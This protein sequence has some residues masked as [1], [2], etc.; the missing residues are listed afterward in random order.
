S[1]RRNPRGSR[2]SASPDFIYPPP[3]GRQAAQAA[4]PSDR[5]ALRVMTSARKWE[6]ERI[7]PHDRAD[8]DACAA[9]RGRSAR[10]AVYIAGTRADPSVEQKYA[11]AVIMTIGTGGDVTTR[12]IPGLLSSGRS[13]VHVHIHAAHFKVHRVW[14]S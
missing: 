6:S 10:H 5:T 14:R 7:R 13:F 8:V 4:Q 11:F 1:N 3:S 9:V 12:H 2:P